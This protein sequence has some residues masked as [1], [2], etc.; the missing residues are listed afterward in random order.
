MPE[1][2]LKVTRILET[3]LHVKDVARS[4]QFYESLFG[5]ARMD[6]NERFC[7]FDVGGGSV[8]L[9]FQAGGTGEPVRTAGGVIPPHGGSGDLHMAFAIRAEDLAAWQ[10]RLQEMGVLIESCVHWERGGTSLY[11][12]DPDHHLIEL[13]TPGIWPSY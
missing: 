13:A 3:A 8:L 9:F 2:K 7:V 12:R 1:D 10:K 5:F 4:A 11:F 6:A